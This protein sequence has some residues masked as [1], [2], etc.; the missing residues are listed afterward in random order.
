METLAAERELL[1]VQET[2][3]ILRLKVS[4]IRAWVCQKRIPYI[5]LGGRSVRIRRADA[6]A[7]IDRGR[8]EA[9]S[10]LGGN[11]ARG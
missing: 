3:A 4:T 1:T 9:V 11:H 10:H 6:L 8:V 5:K 2:A 7:F